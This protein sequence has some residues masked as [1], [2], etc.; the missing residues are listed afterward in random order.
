MGKCITL[1]RRLDLVRHASAFVGVAVCALVYLTASA[2]EALAE[3]VGVVGAVNTAA[4][5]TVPD[6]DTE[7]IVIGRSVLFNELVETDANG[8]VHLMML[9]RTTLTIGPNSSLLIDKF[10]YDPKSRSGEIRLTLKRGLMRFVGGAISKK[11]AV[12]I[13]TPVATIGVRGGIALVSVPS[14]EETEA[15]FLFGQEMSI[16]IAGKV[17]E[18]ITRPGFFTKLSAEFG[19]SSPQRAAVA[20]IKSKLRSLQGTRGQNGGAGGPVDPAAIS[21]GLSKALPDQDPKVLGQVLN[22]ILKVS[23]PFTNTANGPL[24]VQSN[25][26]QPF[27]EPLDQM[28]EPKEEYQYYSG[29]GVSIESV[30]VQIDIPILAAAPDSREE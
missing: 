16:E 9:D 13:K 26:R 3:K 20:A 19:A 21:A 2:P 23:T 22:K 4:T 6:G 12:G 14:P 8:R 17:V 7:E 25:L 18:T 1:L 30:I 10:V 5:G 28:E 29:S 24:F 27:N 11:K 15:T